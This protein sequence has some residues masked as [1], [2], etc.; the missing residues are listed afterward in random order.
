MTSFEGEKGPGSFYFTAQFRTIQ[1]A[2][3]HPG[4]RPLSSPPSACHGAWPRVDAQSL[5]RSY[6]GTGRYPAAGFDSVPNG[7]PLWFRRRAG[8]ENNARQ[9]R[10]PA[11]LIRSQ[12]GVQRMRGNQGVALSQRVCRVA[13]PTVVRRVVHHGG[14]YGVELDIVRGSARYLGYLVIPTMT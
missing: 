9:P 1:S 3:D 8:G 12:G 5:A 10:L 4:P 13:A 2:L 11:C 6:P 7:Y 14:T